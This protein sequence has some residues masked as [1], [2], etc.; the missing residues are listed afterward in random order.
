[1]GSYLQTYGIEEEH[2]GRIIK[3]LL[4]AVGSVLAV[5]LLGYL[6]FHNYP[7]KRVVNSFLDKI[8]A[9]NYQSAYE[10]WGCT[11][12]HPCPNYDYQRFL[13]DWGPASKAQAPWRVASVDSCK[14]FLTVNVQAPGA[15][16]QS[17]AI[18]RSDKSLGFA[19][20]P[21][22]QEKKW[23]WGQFFNRIFHRSS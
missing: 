16:L 14:S 17:L 7:E 6:F 8:N 2:R 21:E 23:R 11:S 20:A 15:E 12:Q 1:V 18:Q 9:R 19:P 22:C 13:Q 5:L 10:Q 4:I 3:R